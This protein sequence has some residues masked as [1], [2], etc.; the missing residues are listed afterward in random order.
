M[1]NKKNILFLPAY[2]DDIHELLY[3]EEFKKFI[4]DNPVSVKTSNAIL[5]ILKEKN[6]DKRLNLLLGYHKDVQRVIVKYLKSVSP[7]KSHS[8]YNFIRV[9]EEGRLFP[10]VGPPKKEEEKIPLINLNLI[11][12][13]KTTNMTAKAQEVL[14]DVQAPALANTVHT[15][16][17]YGMFKELEGNRN[18]NPLHLK[19]LKASMESKYL[20]SPIIVNEDYAVI[21][22]QHRLHCAQELGLP[23]YY[24]VCKGYGLR[25]VQILNASSQNWNADD[26]MQGYCDLGY[27]DYEVYKEF[28]EKY[29]FGHRETQ[30]LLEGS[31]IKNMQDFY[32]GKFK[33]KDR[34]K[35]AEMADKLVK[36]APYF[37]GYKMRS[38]VFA[39]LHMFKQKQFDFNEF[40]KKLEAQP[41]AL[42]KRANTEQY[43]DLIENIYNYRRRDKVSLKYDNSK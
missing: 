1:S 9:F 15:T 35:A 25:E 13:D 12:T 2:F 5:E 18:L 16:R 17:D 30:A 10:F 27:K 26:Y 21:D 8:K 7:A 11:Q 36:I 33:V 39:M 32:L 4:K 23:V 41:G 42:Q 3:S 43:K 28:R 19:R 40:L 37:D 6:K 24:I 20:F 14:T 38:F 29:G 34:K 22:G 31:A